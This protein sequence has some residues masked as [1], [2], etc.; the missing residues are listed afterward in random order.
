MRNNI[1][2]ADIS[3]Y[4]MLNFKVFYDSN[5]NGITESDCNVRLFLHLQIKEMTVFR[6]HVCVSAEHS[7]YLLTLS[8][9]FSLLSSSLFFPFLYRELN[10]PLSICRFKLS[11]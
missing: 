11:I 4:W 8:L 6:V 1:N 10:C 2:F 7:S 9:S 5:S 3:V